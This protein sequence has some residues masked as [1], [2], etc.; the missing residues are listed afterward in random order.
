MSQDY[1]AKMAAVL[2]RADKAEMDALL[3]LF[4]VVEQRQMQRDSLTVDALRVG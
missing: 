1:N 3:E 2:E 4:G